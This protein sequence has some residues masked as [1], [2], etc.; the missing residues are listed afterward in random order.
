V[1]LAVPDLDE[2]FVFQARH[3]SANTAFVHTQFLGDIGRAMKAGFDQVKH[4]KIERDFLTLNRDL[5]AG[6]RFKDPVARPFLFCRI[7]LLFEC[8]LK[9]GT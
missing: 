8:G 9:P 5:A 3:G 2:F 6:M 1:I 7:A 4:F